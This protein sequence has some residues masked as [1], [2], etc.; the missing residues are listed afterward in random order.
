MIT[1]EILIFKSRGWCLDDLVFEILSES[2]DTKLLER[3]TK[4][5]YQ[6]KLLMNEDIIYKW[7]NF[8]GLSVPVSIN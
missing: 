1:I 5:T 7:Q 2:F 6:F 3:S 8:K 4:T